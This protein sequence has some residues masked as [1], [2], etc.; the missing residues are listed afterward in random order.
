VTNNLLLRI[1]LKEL[2]LGEVDIDSHASRIFG[3]LIYMSID[4]QTCST[5]GS[6]PHATA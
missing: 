2:Q 4:S 1:R 3:G 5:S 6:A